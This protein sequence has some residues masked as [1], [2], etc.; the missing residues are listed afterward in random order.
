M[1]CRTG[2]AL[3]SIQ[4][5]DPLLPP[6]RVHE[7]TLVSEL[8]RGHLALQPGEAAKHHALREYNEAGLGALTVLMRKERTPVSW[9]GAAALLGLG[10]GGGAGASSCSEL[11]GEGRAP[12]GR[13]GNR[14][15]HLAGPGRPRASRGMPARECCCTMMHR[16][17]QIIRKQCSKEARAVGRPACVRQAWPHPPVAPRTRP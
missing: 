13:Q 12:A 2:A 1:P 9:Q 3:R 5:L 8:L 7:N 17:A 14:A 4:S 10:S 6:A 11:V 15:W 16:V